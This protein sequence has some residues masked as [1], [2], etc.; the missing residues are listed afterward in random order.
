MSYRLASVGLACMCFGVVALEGCNPS[1][2]LSNG[3]VVETGRKLT[4]ERSSRDYYTITCWDM[5]MLPRPAIIHLPASS[6]TQ[7]LYFRAW[8]DHNVTHPLRNSVFQVEA[9]GAI[10]KTIALRTQEVTELYREYASYGWG[11][12]GGELVEVDVPPGVNAVTLR[13]TSGDWNVWMEFSDVSLGSPPKDIAGLTPESLDTKKM[14]RVSCDIRLIDIGS[15]SA[16][17]SASA[18]SSIENLSGLAETLAQKL[19]TGL[20]AKGEPIAV[21]TLRNRSGTSLG[22]TVADE[23]ADKVTGA[24]IDTGWFDVKERIDLSA[25]LDEKDLDTVGIVKNENVRKKVTGVKYIV[26]GGVT[27]TGPQKQ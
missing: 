21:V 10:V 19:K 26:I 14:Q 23:V 7:K 20:P 9:N 3:I 15:G 4:G 25:F 22:R 1:Y 27:V 6:Q 5:G 2:Q 13:H 12:A 24:L 18:E 16:E 17:A 11:A 8:N